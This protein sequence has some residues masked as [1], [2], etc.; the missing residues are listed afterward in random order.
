[1]VPSFWALDLF[2]ANCVKVRGNE[3][4]LNFE[5]PSGRRRRCHRYGF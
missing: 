4:Y 3:Q 2:F 5:S 1:L